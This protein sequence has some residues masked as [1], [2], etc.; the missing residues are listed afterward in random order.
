MRQE[1]N[2]KRIRIEKMEAQKHV[3][4]TMLEGINEKLEKE[5]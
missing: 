3:K 5:G 1:E 2:E 4:L